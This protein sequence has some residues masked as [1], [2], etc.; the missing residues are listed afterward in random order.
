[1]GGFGYGCGLPCGGYGNECYNNNCNENACCA[2]D[3]RDSVSNVQENCFGKR[4]QVYW[5]NEEVFGNNKT[6]CCADRRRNNFN[7]YNRGARNNAYAAQYPGYGYGGG[8]GGC[9]IGGG[10]GVGAKVY[11]GVHKGLGYK[12]YAKSYHH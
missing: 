1:M 12:P 4:R 11:G 5:E 9:G 8:F 10:C 3:A 7:N 2:A 6:A